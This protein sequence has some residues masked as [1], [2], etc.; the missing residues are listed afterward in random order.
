MVTILADPPIT[1]LFGDIAT[2][3][4]DEGTPVLDAD[5]DLIGLCTRSEDGATHVVDVT[6]QSPPAPVGSAP[7][8][9][10]PATTD[11]PSVTVA[12][13]ASTTAAP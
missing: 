5:G 1:I 8:S 7:P 12:S 13:G 2:V 10:T 11:P 6:G 9:T 4:A 3:G